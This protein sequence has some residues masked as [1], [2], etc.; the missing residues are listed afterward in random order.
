MKINTTYFVMAIVVSFFMSSAYAEDIEAR[1]DWSQRVTLST[2]VSGIISAINVKPGQQVAKDALMLS[3]DQSVFKARLLDAEQALKSAELDMQEGQ[4]EWERSQELYERTVL[5]DHEL[6]TAKVLFA[7]SQAHFQKAQADLEQARFDMKYSSI[8]AP[9]AGVVVDVAVSVG[10]TVIH[11]M[12]S[13]PMLVLA[14]N[15]ALIAE[16]Y[17]S[18]K[19]ARSLSKSSKVSVKLGGNNINGTISSLGVEPQD[20]KYL[21]RVQFEANGKMFRKGEKAEIVLP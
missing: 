9:F 6:A 7:K 18:A 13:T 2:P 19:Q 20:G 11:N 1:L 17:I 8:K 16:A 10:Q 12:Q 3:L 14:N 21:L 15:R 5:S 4:K